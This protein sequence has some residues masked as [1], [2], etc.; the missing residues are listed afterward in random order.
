MRSSLVPIWITSFEFHEGEGNP[1]EGG[2]GDGGKGGDGK[3][4]ENEGLTPEE[5]AKSD[6]DSLKKALEAERRLRTKA[7][8]AN[9]VKEQAE[10]DKALQEQG[11][12]VALKT[13]LEREQEKNSK[14]AR[15]YLADKLNDAIREEARSL[16]FIDVTD[17]LTDKVRGEISVEQDD[18]EPSTVVIDMATL[19][20]A[21]KNLASAKPHLIKSG[22]EDGEPTG[23]SMGGK[24]KKDAPN[25][26]EKLEKLYRL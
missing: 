11:E 4:V 7:E 10:A 24:G 25:E 15:G 8:K 5:L 19:K 18:D 16:N 3:P 22:T 6:V 21:V 2:D 14:L 9:K 23:S 20:T 17:A 12:I 1:P 26:R 13:K